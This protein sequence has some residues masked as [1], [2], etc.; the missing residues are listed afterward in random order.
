LRASSA[1]TR[2]AAA[3]GY[4]QAHRLDGGL[5]PALADD[6]P[7]VRIAAAES[8]LALVSED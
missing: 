8:M 4:Q 6:D 1:A 2:R 5:V 7:L 3:A